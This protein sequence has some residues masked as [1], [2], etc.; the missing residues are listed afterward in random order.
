MSVDVG[1]QISKVH[2]ASSSWVFEGGL[3]PSESRWLA[4]P[5][6][7]LSFRGH[8]KPIHGSCAI[9]FSGGIYSFTT[10][11]CGLFQLGLIIDKIDK[12]GLVGL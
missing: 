4:T 1:E 6:R 2:V 7:W 9:Y 11:T 3:H 5:K 12:E 8:D 10:I